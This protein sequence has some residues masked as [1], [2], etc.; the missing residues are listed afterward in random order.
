VSLGMVSRDAIIAK[1]LGV[2][3]SIKRKRHPRFLYWWA[4]LTIP[5]QTT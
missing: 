1:V 5:P 3:K 2:S 4:R